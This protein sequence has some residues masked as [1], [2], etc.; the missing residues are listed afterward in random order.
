MQVHNQNQYNGHQL[1][2][3]YQS[4]LKDPLN[5]GINFKNLLN[6]SVD[7]NLQA[8]DRSKLSKMLFIPLEEE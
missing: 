1:I 5:A 4:K 6:N 2:K 3:S 8:T 7:V